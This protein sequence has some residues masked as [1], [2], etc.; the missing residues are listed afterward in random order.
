MRTMDHVAAV[1]WVMVVVDLAEVVV[2]LLVVMQKMVFLSVRQRRR[3]ETAAGALK[4]KALPSTVRLFVNS[5]INRPTN[6]TI[7]FQ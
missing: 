4:M 2:N 3:R 1:D 6:G 7:N 5:T